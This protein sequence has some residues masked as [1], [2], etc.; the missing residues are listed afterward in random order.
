MNGHFGNVWMHRVVT[1]CFSWLEIDHIN[2]DKTDNRLA[3]LRMVAHAENMRNKAK[4][5][6]NTSGCVGVSF[7]KD[8]KKWYAYVNKDGVRTSLGFFGSKEEAAS[9]ATRARTEMGFVNVAP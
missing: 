7:V 9:V 5:A 8:K 1:G 4:Y 6:N 3:N 2:R